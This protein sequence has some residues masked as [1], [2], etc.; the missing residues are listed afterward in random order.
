LLSAEGE[1]EGCGTGVA[2]RTVEVEVDLLQAVQ[3]ALATAGLSEGG[4][5]HSQVIGKVSV[6]RSTILGVSGVVGSP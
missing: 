2:T 3:A 6:E 5:G 4:G 1:E